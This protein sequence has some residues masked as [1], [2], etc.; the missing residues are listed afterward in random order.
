M[1]VWAKKYAK[2]MERYEKDPEYIKEGYILEFTEEI[3]RV[4]EE[5]KINRRQLAK[6]MKTSPAYITKILRGNANFTFETVAKF[7]LALGQ[8]YKFSF[9]GKEEA[10]SSSAFDCNFA[11]TID[12]GEKN[13]KILPFKKHCWEDTQSAKSLVTI[14]GG[15]NE[16][17]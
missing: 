5:K 2:M 6:L 13:N 17:A 12:Y 10:M 4:M 1:V 11:A 9:I 15:L 3:C 8:E 14:S 16:I 7:A